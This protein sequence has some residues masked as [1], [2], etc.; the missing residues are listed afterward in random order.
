MIDLE[1]KFDM[2]RM[3]ASLLAAV[4]DEARRRA[5]ATALTRVAF[6][7]RA[8]VIKKMPQ[9]FDRPTPF[10]LKSVRYGGATADALAARAYVTEDATGG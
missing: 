9:V 2:A 7:A 1:V 10:T 3:E 4:G 5:T 8:E 6:A